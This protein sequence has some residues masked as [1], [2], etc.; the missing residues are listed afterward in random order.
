RYRAPAGAGMP[1]RR[2]APTPFHR[3]LVALSG[4]PRDVAHLDA[5]V[6]LARHADAGLALVHVIDVSSSRH[7]PPP[8][9]A[10]LRETTETR[11][12]RERERLL[13][14]A[15]EAVPLEMA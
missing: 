12:A 14:L 1:A 15:N 3:M 10:A 4:G 8:V 5:A 13:D 7:Q 11:G 9:R 2:R 6:E